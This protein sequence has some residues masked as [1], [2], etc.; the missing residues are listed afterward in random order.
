VHHHKT[1]LNQRKKSI[2]VVI[3][4]PI[5]HAS[6]PMAASIYLKSLENKDIGLQLSQNC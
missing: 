4:N 1:A 2:T 6:A 3:A 5:R